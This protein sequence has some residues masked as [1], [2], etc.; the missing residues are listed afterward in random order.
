M[1]LVDKLSYVIERADV[2]FDPMRRKSRGND[3]IRVELDMRVSPEVLERLLAMI[4]AERAPEEEHRELPAA[5]TRLPPAVLSR[6]GPRMLGQG[7]RE[8]GEP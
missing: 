6:S 3:L 5:P 2:G 4:E 8:G 7:R 1:I